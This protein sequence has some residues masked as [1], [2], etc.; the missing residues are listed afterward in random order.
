M[1]LVTHYTYNILVGFA[2]CVLKITK[3][4]QFSSFIFFLYLY[5]LLLFLQLHC[6]FLMSF[7]CNRPVYNPGPC[8]GQAVA[9]V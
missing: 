5:Y 2:C 9:K 7:L 6:S 8:S 3:S 4:Q 1:L